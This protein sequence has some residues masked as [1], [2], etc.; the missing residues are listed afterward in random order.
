MPAHRRGDV[1][2]I[3]RILSLLFGLMIKNF[4]TVLAALLLL[5]GCGS[6]LPGVTIRGY[7]VSAAL[8]QS[9]SADLAASSDAG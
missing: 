7:A 8:P 2:S 3:A 4:L 9:T 6:W 5:S 1:I